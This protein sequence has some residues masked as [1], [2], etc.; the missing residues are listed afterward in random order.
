M[1]PGRRNTEVDILRRMQVGED[2][3][4]NPKMDWMPWRAGV[5]A[6]LDV[7]RGR[8]F[9]EGQ[10]RYAETVYKLTFDYL[11]AIG[12]NQEMRVRF[13]GT[14]MDIKQIRVDYDTRQEIVVEA[15]DAE[16]RRPTPL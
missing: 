15:T 16:G 1:D 11:D 7:I 12:V 5:W 6:N 9:I 8:E 10:Q 3:L 13:E 2:S 4:G 14:E